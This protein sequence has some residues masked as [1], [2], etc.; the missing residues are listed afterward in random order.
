MGST[1]GRIV[2]DLKWVEVN[3]NLTQKSFGKVSVDTTKTKLEMF[4]LVP[5]QAR[6]TDT[7]ENGC[8]WWK[9]ELETFLLALQASHSS[10]VKDDKVMPEI[11][12]K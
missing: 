2:S 1:L 12:K 11:H 6:Q 9:V 7:E 8:D 5:S 10:R 4:G 3:L